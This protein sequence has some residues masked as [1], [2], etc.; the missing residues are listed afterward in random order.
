MTAAPGDD[1]GGVHPA[2]IQR[3]TRLTITVGDVQALS[4]DIEVVEGSYSITGMKGP[5]G[6]PLP[7][8][9]GYHVVTSV[10]KGD[11]WPIAGGAAFPPAPPAPEGGA[12][13]ESIQRASS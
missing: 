6:Q 4:A 11:A 12:V 5:D 1:A 9:M 8:Q 13:A 2:S 7:A 3:R 10:K